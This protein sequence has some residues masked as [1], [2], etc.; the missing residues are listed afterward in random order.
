MAI[1]SNLMTIALAVSGSMTD[2]N[3]QYEESSLY[4]PLGYH[5]YNLINDVDQEQYNQYIDNQIENDMVMSKTNV[6]VLTHGMGGNADHWLVKNEAGQYIETDYSLPFVL[7]N[8]E[9]RKNEISFPLEGQGNIFK[10]NVTDNG[11][12]TLYKLNE[13]GSYYRFDSI[14]SFNQEDIYSQIVL[15][16][17][18]EDSNFYK[19]EFGENVPKSN[20]FIYNLFKNSLNTILTDIA[21]LQNGYVPSV[22]LIGHSRGGI[23]NMLYAN[24]YPEIVN[25]LIS[26][27]TP[28]MGSQWAE[29]YVA[30][31]KLTDSG[32]TAYDDMLSPEH[33]PVYSSAFNAISEEVN[34]YAIGFKQ[35][36]SYFVNTITTLLTGNSN[37]IDELA[38]QICEISNNELTTEEAY[39]IVDNL[40]GALI[41][42][43]TAIIQQSNIGLIIG[44][45]R[46]IVEVL[47]VF[48]DN[49]IITNL[50]S[51]LEN[52]ED[53][54]KKDILLNENSR[55]SHI[56][57]DIC[58]NLDSQLGY[59]R[60]TETPYYN[61]SDTETIVLGDTNNNNY[62][63]SQHCAIS[64]LPWVAH[65]FETKNPTAINYIIDFLNLHQGF[66]EHY[67][68]WSNTSTTHSKVCSCGVVEMEPAN[69]ELYVEQSDET[70][71][72]Y[73]CGF[74]GC[75]H[76][77][78][79]EHDFRYEN[80]ND[81]IHQKECN[82]CEYTT[83]ESHLYNV[84]IYRS[85]T[86]HASYCKCGKYGKESSHS[87]AITTGRC[88]CGAV[89]RNEPIVPVLPPIR[90]EPITGTS[91]VET[92]Y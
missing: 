1:I 6:T 89:G 47:D 85:I 36:N 78:F 16:Y 13:Y 8:D 3:I 83:S 12:I 92:T 2:G 88:V 11:I 56:E 15:I 61:F 22:N 25:N 7:C 72:I 76:C 65:N 18:G 14:N 62:Y 63:D 40:F 66:H 41:N 23:I 82:V 51:L 27:G 53:I 80:I 26:L 38:E 9:N 71:H 91:G 69:H 81:S 39:G 35:T 70:T 32:F 17:E 60:E 87:Y 44:E 54:L 29:V 90:P 57:S 19:N 46:F 50:R 34:S 43:G 4:D 52:F 24:E 28:Y 31:N 42:L 37:L 21:N 58:V 67:F 59:I 5:E 68:F 75:S 74:D 84:Y 64:T 49:P 55:L 86:K 73:R 10:F 79:E 20:Q 77:F 33:L 45:T 30:L 48:V